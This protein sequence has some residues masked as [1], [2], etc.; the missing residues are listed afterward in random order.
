MLGLTPPSAARLLASSS[1]SE[2]QMDALNA[3]RNWLKGVRD[4]G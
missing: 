3:R 2:P 1:L 4:N